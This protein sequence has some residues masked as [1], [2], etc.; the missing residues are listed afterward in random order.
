MTL[1]VAWLVFPLVLATITLGG[2]LALEAL[3]GTRLPLALLL[4]AGLAAV[5]VVMCLA[6]LTDATAEL[7]VP[8]VVALAVVGLG[9][10]A[11]GLRARFDPWTAGV[12]ITA[13][14]VYAAPIVA[15]GQ[16]TFAGYV[17]LD[18]TATW[19]GTLDYVLERGTHVTGLA[20]STYEAMLTLWLGDGYPIGSFVPLGVTK[21]LDVD[22]AWTWQPYL[23]FLAAL[24]A[25]VLHELDRRP[26]PLAS[27][28][29]PRRGDGERIRA[30]LRLRALGRRQGALH[31]GPARAARRDRCRHVEGTRPDRAR[32]GRRAAA[33]LDGLS[34]AGAIWLV[35]LV[36]VV[37][38]GAWRHRALVNVAVAAGAT[39][40]LA[41]PAL[42]AAPAFLG[43]A[44]DVARGTDDTGNLL[45]PLS[46][47]QIAGIW[48]TADFRVHPEQH[49]A[50][51]VLVGV[52]LAACAYGVVVAC[53]RRAWRLLSLF[54]T[55]VV[56]ALVFHVSSGPWIEAKALATASPVV[57]VLALVGGATLVESG[58]RIE[59]ALVL[60]AL[61]G[62]VAWSNVLGASDAHLAPR[63]Q[64]AEL[65]AIG[66]R[67]A[68]DGPAL[69]T[70]Y[71]P[72]GVRHFLRRL[73]PEGA[74]ELRRRP[75]QL[76]DG[77]LL[78]KGETAPIDAFAP[79]ALLVY[80]TLVL[81][82]SGPGGIPPSPFSARRTRALLRRLAA[83]G[84]RWGRA[85]D[86]FEPVGRCT[87]AG[88]GYTGSGRVGHAERVHGVAWIVV[89]ERRGPEARVRRSV[90]DGQPDGI[91]RIA[92]LEI[93]RLIAAGAGNEGSA[94]AATDRVVPVPAVRDDEGLVG[95]DHGHG[96]RQAARRAGRA[97]RPR[98]SCRAR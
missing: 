92:A 63:G 19:L 97:C 66:D 44:N 2:G 21:L 39:L 47:W 5:V 17:K 38:V 9:V 82:R 30:P 33:F 37:L 24:L 87:S 76:R 36:I 18:D 13:Y 85:G 70:E 26:R 94:P 41:L 75:V 35:P 40:A 4:P 64:L 23:S 86:T 8:L 1:V 32:A 46:P 74:S 25:L 58:R 98:R 90:G 57:L 62:G 71:Q 96:D 54:A 45:G 51:I 14:A 89:E 55:A 11:R 79:E 65:E 77:R 42:L 84:L 80:R 50:T 61:V 53:R 49:R 48:P 34:V 31:G 72:Y 10:G 69:M 22:P 43:N 60:A 73:D 91:R 12:G 3:A 7:A 16:A 15:S 81:L 88:K 68:G 93:A 6:T 56:G 52:A 20:P 78:S 27:P 28:A 83:A 95:S 29:G 67:Y 59:G